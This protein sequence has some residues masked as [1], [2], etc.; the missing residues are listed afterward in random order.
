M[1]TKEQFMNGVLSYIEN[2]VI[3]HLP[4]AG[5]WGLGALTLLASTKANAL[6]ASLAQNTLVKSLGIIN[7]EGLINL[8]SLSEALKQSAEKYGAVTFQTILG[9]LTFNAA[10]IDKLRDYI[11]GKQWT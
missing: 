4:T 8:N 1:V 9:N 5:K 3:P 2:E 11:E 6:Y 7:N 10:D